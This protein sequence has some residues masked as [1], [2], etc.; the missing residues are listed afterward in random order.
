MEQTPDVSVIIPNYNSAHTIERAINSALSQQGVSVQVIVVDDA[1]TDNSLNILEQIDHPSLMVLKLHE[2]QGTANARNEGLKRATGTWI[3]FLD[4]DDALEPAKL[5]SQLAVS[6]GADVV[7]SDWS[8]YIDETSM[9]K[10]SAARF[11]NSGDKYRLLLHGNQMPVH[12]PIAK[13]D[14]L[15]RLGGFNSNLY[16]EDWE[17]WIRLFRLD[18]KTAY[19]QGN[20]ARYY[21]SDR[22]KSWD[23][24][25]TIEK[26]LD[27]IDYLLSRE[28]YQSE[29]SILEKVHRSIKLDLF[30]AL[31][32]SR[33]KIAAERILSELGKKTI[34]E[35]LTIWAVKSG[36]LFVLIKR[37]YG[38]NR[39]K[40]KILEFLSR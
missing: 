20:L 1:S 9:E 3:Q 40:R 28:G 14:L 10:A 25:K 33:E 32:N 38:P 16:H 26:R 29:R 11:A 31:W 2:R 22:G 5:A 15:Q 6:R 13:R 23:L 8:I 21:R 34:S 7:L 35:H 36:W 4:A 27:L 17:Y 30:A 39:L 37:G 24:V 12:V 18:P 19:C